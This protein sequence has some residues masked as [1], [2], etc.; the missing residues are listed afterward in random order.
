MILEIG[1]GTDNS[2]RFSPRRCDALYLDIEKPRIFGDRFVLGSAEYLPF[3]DNSFDEIYASHVI[4]H[5]YEP[6]IFLRDAYRALKNKG[7]LY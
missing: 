2:Y 7:L 1:P 4:E 6:D 5:L 3:R